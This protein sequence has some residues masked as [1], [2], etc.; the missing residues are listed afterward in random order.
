MT[1]ICEEVCD[2]A[3]LG[4]SAEELAARLAIS[5]Q[6]I[7]EAIRRGLLSF[8]LHRG[9]DCWRLGD[10][11]N[12]CLRRLDGQPFQINGER[13]KAKAETRGESWH[14]LIGLDDV[15][16][17]DRRDILLILEGSKDALSALHF[18]DAEDT[19]SQVGV[20]AALSASVNLL[21]DDIEK[22]RGCRVRIFGD[23]DTAG[24]HA[25]DRVGQ[26]L[27]SV[28]AEVQI[29][30]VAGLNRD[31]GEPVKDLFDV[32]RID[33]DDFERERDI[34]S[35]SDLAS[36]GPRVRVVEQ[37]PDFFSLPSNSALLL[38]NKTAYD[39]SLCVTKDNQ[40][41]TNDDQGWKG[42]ERK[43]ISLPLIANSFDLFKIANSLACRENGKGHRA[44]FQLAR[45]VRRL[46]MDTGQ[47]LNNDELRDVHRRWF[48][49]S[50]ALPAEATE[51][52]AFGEFIDRLRKVRIIPGTTGDTLRL[53]KQR[54][55]TLPLPEIPGFTD[56]PDSM[57]KIAALHRELQRASNGAPHFCTAEDAREFAA[58]KHKTEAHRIQLRLAD[59]RLG[60][61]RCVKRGVPRKGGKPTLWLYL[62][63][64]P[65]VLE[66][67]FNDS[68]IR[69]ANGHPPSPTPHPPLFG[70]REQ[71]MKTYA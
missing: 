7:E 4:S 68:Q 39:H 48:S 71:Q 59:D 51:A 25:A 56:A 33:V 49:A 26:Q 18:A 28:A 10:T 44:Q 13:V 19:L 15:V 63:P 61:L 43:E 38:R 42:K 53:A 1:A 60:V 29:F 23:A 37:K 24:E 31:D 20:V 58:L 52:E 6:A 54:A 57:R 55:R 14:R 32:T 65:P 3:V 47:P 35:I 2:V 16:A 40:R 70:E 64:I 8:V 67:D 45:Y 46:E 36:R 69:A 17:N 9:V 34:W 62:L 22:F 5:V 30:N 50:T 11:R 27:A 41:I 66:T 21:A 12:G